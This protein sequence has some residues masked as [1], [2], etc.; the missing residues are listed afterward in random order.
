MPRRSHLA[1]AATLVG[2]Y[3]GAY[4]VFRY[5]SVEVWERDQHAYVIF[6]QGYGVAL[7]YLWRPLSY[8]DGVL[9]G[10]RFHIGRIVRD[11]TTGH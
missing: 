4:L 1:T 3:V 6:P 5:A 8:I 2:L 10:M 9:T 11:G 7:H